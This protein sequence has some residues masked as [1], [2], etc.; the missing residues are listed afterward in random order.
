MIGECVS[1]MSHAVEQFGGMVQ[2]YMGDGIAAFF[3]M[4]RAHEDDAERA[5]RAALAIAADVS[6]YAEEVRSAWQISD[7]NVR[8]GIN[9][10]VTAVG[11]VG[12]ASPQAVSMG[13]TTNVAARL[14]SIAEPGSIVVG[15][16]TA[17]I[18]IRTFA[19]EP[20]GRVTVKGRH[21]P[22]STWRLI[23]PQAALRGRPA[24]ALSSTA[25]PSWLACERVLD[26]LESAAARSPSCSARRESERPAC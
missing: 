19:L 18:L 2:A 11:L 17:K 3:G 4:P 8:I 10:G 15:E 6:E 26:E 22:V 12:A 5:A 16:A 23:G 21:E 25:T 14:Q 7:F 20:L 1:R 13:D 24:P 9:T